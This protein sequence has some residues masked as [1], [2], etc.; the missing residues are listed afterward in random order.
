MIR[1]FEDN[2]GRRAESGDWLHNG[3]HEWWLGQPVPLALAEGN[4]MN[5]LTCE[6]IER[7]KRM[8]GSRHVIVCGGYAR[9][10]FFNRKPKDVDIFVHLGNDYPESDAFAQAED[11]CVW[12]RCRGFTT[13]VSQAYGQTGAHDV[14]GEATRFDERHYAI[15]QLD[16]GELSIDVLFTRAA[17]VEQTLMKFDANI[18]QVYI[19]ELGGPT[20][21]YGNPPINLQFLKEVTPERAA[22]IIRIAQELRI[23]EG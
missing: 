21:L 12:A 22:H 10:V 4:D 16:L 15:A 1:I 6:V 11:I 13:G 17:S 14:R 8:A 7:L 20:W 2:R 5:L 3:H 19:D 9:D 18:N 23:H